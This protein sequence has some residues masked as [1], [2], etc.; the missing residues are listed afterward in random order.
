MAK[1]I[2]IQLNNDLELNI[3]VVKDSNGKITSGLT[4]GNTLYQNQYLILQAQKGEFKENPTL[5]VGIND[6]ANDD[7]LTEW[8][9]AIRQELAKDGMKINKLVLTNSGMS[10]EARY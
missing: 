6:M 10:L 7:D 1:D 9:K 5:G 8:K 4:V 2:G 3:Q